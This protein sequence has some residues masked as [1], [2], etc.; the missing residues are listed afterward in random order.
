MIDYENVIEHV[1]IVHDIFEWKIEEFEFY[2]EGIHSKV[3][4]LCN[5]FM[6]KYDL[7]QEEDFNLFGYNNFY[8][9][10]QIVKHKF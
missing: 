5:Q 3:S 4:L 8:F 7:H 2:V 9:D 10:V 1:K 6:W